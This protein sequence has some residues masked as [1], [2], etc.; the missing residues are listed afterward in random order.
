MQV[1]VLTSQAQH[2]YGDRSRSSSSHWPRHRRVDELHQD[3]C[4]FP[5]EVKGDLESTGLA[6]PSLF[7]FP[8]LLDTTLSYNMMKMWTNFAKT[9]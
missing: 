9:G 5:T 6:V 4:M 2:A 1:C 7:C 8:E 3:V